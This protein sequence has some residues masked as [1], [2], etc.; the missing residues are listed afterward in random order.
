MKETY[1]LFAGL[2]VVV[3]AGCEGF[4]LEAVCGDGSSPNFE[5]DIRHCGECFTSCLR[6][7]MRSTCEDRQCQFDRC[8]P[9]WVD[10]DED[11]ANG[12][13]CEV[14]PAI[15]GSCT[16]RMC[17]AEEL[18]HNGY[19]DDCDGEIDEGSTL[20]SRAHCGAPH[21]S[22]L[23]SPGAEDVECR[24]Q[25][26]VSVGDATFEP[27]RGGCWD[28]FDED[29]NGIRDDGPLCEVLLPNDP[30]QRCGTNDSPCGP[31]VFAMG[32]NGDGNQRSLEYPLHHVTLSH[33][34]IFDRYEATRQQFAAFLDATGL[35][36][37]EGDETPDPRCDVPEDERLLPVGGVNWC[38]AYDYCHWMGKRL[39]T[40]AEWARLAGGTTANFARFRPYPRSGQPGIWAPQDGSEIPP[41][42]TL[43]ESANTD[44]EHGGPVVPACYPNAE[45][46]PRPVSFTA[47]RR[48]V[49]DVDV[50]CADPSGSREPL[51]PAQICLDRHASA[52]VHVAGNVWEW[53]FDQ[54]THYC[55]RIEERLR[56]RL[57]SDQD[58][59]GDQELPEP[60]CR[61]GL[62]GGVE[63][64]V[65]DREPVLIRDPL[66][67]DLPPH[68]ERILRGGG[69]EGELQGS[70]FFNRVS[71]RPGTDSESYGVRCARTFSPD[72]LGMETRTPYDSSQP[73]SAWAS[74]VSTPELDA[75]IQQPVAQ[76]VDFC[77]PTLTE[78]ENVGY[79]LA[80]QTLVRQETTPPGPTFVLARVNDER[81]S[82]GHADVEAGVWRWL[83]GADIATAR[84]ACD[85]DDCRLDFAPPDNWLSIWW[86]ATGRHELRFRIDSME[87]R[88]M[89]GARCNLRAGPGM[90]RWVARVALSAASPFM[91]NDQP[92]P[93]VLCDN[94]EVECTVEGFEG[95]LACRDCPSWWL[96][97][98]MLLEPLPDGP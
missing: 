93:V 52:A 35:C 97:W 3:A 39:P 49:G 29:N 25:V 55:P 86:T 87:R 32:S 31:T 48:L 92:L 28:A 94:F 53:T 22:C 38:E 9:G 24:D 37:D 44:C 61:D 5:S 62:G 43:L 10:W 12:C 68:S 79:G 2:F 69:A 83:A 21:L 59:D 14:D 84:R 72:A 42:A 64:A 98:E 60:R 76:M 30:G 70:R 91:F 51:T 50:E 23:L 15:E 74:C 78:G 7:N 34:V 4:R 18:D 8:E 73:S 47:G 57:E 71:A 67:A 41:A 6:P 88:P 33:D 11:P 20:D 77:V 65:S 85:D 54:R 45:D 27:A 1:L 56:A 80:V 90:E 36:N 63:D 82:L 17:R 66:I 16:A 96:E 13:E 46:R 81:S 75:P 26:C 89:E 19:D 40:E 95:R 58:E